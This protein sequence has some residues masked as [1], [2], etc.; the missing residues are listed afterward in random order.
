MLSFMKTTTN[1]VLAVGATVVLSAAFRALTEGE[2]ALDNRICEVVDVRRAG[3]E[4]VYRVCGLHVVDGATCR[5]Y[6]S[7][8][9]DLFADDLAAPYTVAA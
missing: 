8:S 5:D 2:H 3:G 4:Y 9:S 6:A 7:V 1:T